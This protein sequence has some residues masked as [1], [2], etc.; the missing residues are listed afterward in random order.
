MLGQVIG[1]YR[2]VSELG[3]GGMGM[4]YVAEH[5]QLGRPAALKMLLPQFSSD[6]AI[7]QRFFNEA[8]AAST[9]D[10]PGIV[11]IYEVGTHVD[12][13]AYIVMA[14]LKGET[15]QQRIAREPLAP[16]EGATI[17]AQVAGALAAAHARNIVHRDLKPDNIF[18]VPNELVPGGL[19][20]KL[21]DFGI[22]KL[23][24]E[25]AS[26]KT[27]T[28]SLIGTPAY[29]SPEQ[30]MG[31]SDV[32]YRTDLYAL[33]CILF[34]VLCGRPPFVSDAGAGVLI[35][36]H[37][38]DRP[39][40]PRMFNPTISEAL[41]AIV[42]RLLEKDP[43]ARFQSANEVRQALMVA[44][45][46]VSLTR[47]ITA[48]QHPSGPR[49][50]RY[51]GPEAYHATNAPTTNSG[52]AAQLVP[53]KPKKTKT[54]LVTALA[55]AGI[56]VASVTTYIVLDASSRPASTPTP[57]AHPP[58]PAPAP[59]P[60]SPP[61]QPP[62]GSA[63]APVADAP[64][65]DGQSRSID[66]SAHCC[67]PDQAWSTSK[68]RCVGTPRCPPGMIAAKTEQCVAQASS[69]KPPPSPPAETGTPVPKF[70]LASE[71]FAPGATIVFNFEKPVPSSGAHRAWVTIVEEGQPKDTYRAWEY[72]ADQA[73]T[74]SIKAP[75]N[76]GRYEARV[77]TDYSTM[78]TNLR[79]SVKLR[80]AGD[81]PSERPSTGDGT[82]LA[83]QRFSITATTFAPKATAQLAFA[84]P[85]HARSGER[86]WVTV[87]RA[88]LPDTAYGAYEY[89]PDGAWTMPLVMPAAPGDYEIR[90]H[91]NFPT[92]SYNVV[93]RTI[94]R[95]E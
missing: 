32:D 29:M 71:V 55:L 72:V 43:A 91:A 76:P 46:N 19:Q 90:L 65:P 14:L 63:T 47:P 45:A 84:A 93:H 92:K 67:W 38:R 22:A 64:C 89:V 5:V 68:G 42:L 74:A 35:A 86:F 73:R 12:G 6:E 25:R 58:P 26:F 61:P 3:K 40:D 52:S 53:A 37:L 11:E 39:P 9:I 1:S 24:D 31:R 59:T 51:R 70:T 16:V 50:A 80:I 34:H 27:Q 75:L 60:P 8:R 49:T 94:V 88:D 83:K 4:V 48:Q 62:A 54:G 82:P 2:I 7:V 33:G 18:L 15:L 85:M 20:S 77:H 69:A 36:A 10:H 23:T 57:A 30:C 81:P 95:I 17:V 28:G 79:Y 13:R 87:V 78:S 41:A 21:L 44:G 56:V 66:T